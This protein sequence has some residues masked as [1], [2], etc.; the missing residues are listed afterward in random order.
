MKQRDGGKRFLKRRQDVENFVHLSNGRL[1][2][3]GRVFDV[4]FAGPGL[5]VNEHVVVCSRERMH[6]SKRER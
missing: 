2:L 3:F 6:T 1:G 5:E 4:R